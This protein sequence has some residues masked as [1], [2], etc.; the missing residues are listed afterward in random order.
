MMGF[1]VRDSEFGIQASQG[2]CCC[3]L[4]ARRRLSCGPSGRSQGVGHQQG[5]GHWPDA[6]GH[7]R[8]RAGLRFGFRVSDVANQ[9]GPSVTIG[10]AVDADIYDSRAG[11]D[12]VTLD[13]LGAANGGHQ[14]IGAA[15]QRRQILGAAV[16]DGHGGVGVE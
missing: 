3:S 7:R 9:P 13:H 12:P 4:K 15:A 10:N 5:D 1:R 2:A 6:S 11:L 16:S 14:D 8:D